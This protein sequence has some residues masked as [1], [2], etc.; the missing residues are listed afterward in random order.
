M[1]TC[2]QHSDS[3]IRGYHGI[4]LTEVEC[5]TLLV[6]L[7]T[8]D[9]TDS[10]ERDEMTADLT[11]LL[12]TGFSSANLLAD[13][14][15]IDEASPDDLRAWRIGESLCQVVLED[16]FLCRFHWNERRDAR[17]PLGNK[18]GADVVGFI[19]TAD[20]V[21]FLFGEAKTSSETANRPPQVMTTSPKG[22]EAQLRELYQNSKKRYV[23]ISYLANKTRALSDVHPFKVDYKAALKTYYADVQLYHLIGVLIRDVDPHVDDVLASYDRLKTT[24]LDPIGLKLLAL[25]TT[26][27]KENWRTIVEGS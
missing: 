20:G 2:Y 3:N 15:A 14:Q 10:E 7:V 4:Q 12:Q 25:Y 5:A 23:L 16:N 19:Q 27:K 18:T 1:S 24:I 26:I 17:N 11:G 6:T 9:L 22:M 13:I 8:D 21:L